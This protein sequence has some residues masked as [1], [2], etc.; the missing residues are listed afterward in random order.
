[1]ARTSRHEQNG[2]ALARPIDP[3]PWG[4]EMD[5]DYITPSARLAPMRWPIQSG[6]VR[7]SVA[8]RLLISKSWCLLEWGEQHPPLRALLRAAAVSTFPPQ[9]SHHSRVRVG[10]IGTD[11]IAADGLAIGRERDEG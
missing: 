10:D 7:G 8:A 4:W 3:P 9:G 11:V 1:M 2:Q 6:R 5:L